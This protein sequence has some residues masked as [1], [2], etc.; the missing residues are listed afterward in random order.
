MHPTDSDV[1]QPETTGADPSGS[2]QTTDPAAAQ[3]AQ[4]PEADKAVPYE[5]FREV[6]EKYRATETKVQTL[7]QR[8]AQMEGRFSP[9]PAQPDPQLAAVKEQLKQLGFVDKTEVEQEIQ[10]RETDAR[11][12]QQL[13]TLE[14]EWDGKDGR[15]A[16]DRREVIDYALKRG[17]PDPEVAFKM[18]REKEIADWR[19]QQAIAKSRGIKSEASDGSGSANAGTTDQDLKDAIAGGDKSA[20]HAYLKRLAQNKG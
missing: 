17:I 3:P 16:F 7:E 11:I 13:A 19:V 5:R 20:L 14:K 4:Q 18:L 10:R 9:P 8:L 2:E 15:P 1:N 12:G 6:N